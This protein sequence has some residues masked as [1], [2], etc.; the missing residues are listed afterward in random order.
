[1]L[2]TLSFLL[3]LWQRWGETGKA[4]G[5]PSRSCSLLPKGSWPQSHSSGRLLLLPAAVA[6]GFPEHKLLL[7]FSRISNTFLGNFRTT[8]YPPNLIFLICKGQPVL[9]QTSIS[10]FSSQLTF[11]QN[12]HQL[13]LLP[14]N[15]SCHSFCLLNN[16]VKS[17][18]S[19]RIV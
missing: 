9:T 16:P 15:H 5:S 7:S 10:T 4:H 1:M 14:A 8:T 17:V 18:I 11:G 12:F 6:L 3:I 2:F 13:W 19:L